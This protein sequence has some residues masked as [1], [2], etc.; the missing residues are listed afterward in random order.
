MNYLA[1]R[2]KMHLML[3]SKKILNSCRFSTMD[4]IMS[5]TL[6]W[7][8]IVLFIQATTECYIPLELVGRGD[9]KKCRSIRPSVRL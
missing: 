7:R 1:F 3:V 5:L 4:M 2:C 8:H 6:L 9:L